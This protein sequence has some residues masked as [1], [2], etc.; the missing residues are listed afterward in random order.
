MR[1]RLA[2]IDSAAARYENI[3]KSRM[4]TRTLCKLTLLISLTALVACTNGSDSEAPSG[5]SKLAL[6]RS[7]YSTTTDA[8]G[9][10]TVQFEVPNGIN[11][12]QL[13]VQSSEGGV[14]FV[15]V[16]GPGATSLDTNNASAG[17]FEAESSIAAI[18]YPHLQERVTP[19]S[20]TA[21]VLVTTGRSKKNPVEGT[22]IAATLL[23]KKD[24]DMNSGVLKVNMALVGP[25]S[26]ADETRDVLEAAVRIWGMIFFR[27]GI[28]LD[29]EWYDFAGPS[30][31]PDPSSG[32]ALYSE[33]ATSVRPGAITMVIASDVRGLGRTRNDRFTSYPSSPGAADPTPLSIAAVSVLEISGRD[34]KFDYY[35]PGSSTTHN[36]EIRL[37]G[38]ELAQLAGHY[39]GL[40]HTVDFGNGSIVSQS[41]NLPDTL[42]CLALTDC[43]TEDLVRSNFM[44]PFPLARQRNGGWGG[45]LPGNNDRYDPSEYRPGREY[46]AREAVTDQQRRV[47]NSSVLVD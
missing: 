1:L 3:I 32:D 39:L 15:S 40:S 16:S 29:V 33:I 41:D 22:P 35:G 30:R 21:R 13:V 24:S 23:T 19:G 34:G 7:T 20:Y 37:A 36:D 6:G 18:N 2:Q 27:A 9:I 28:T 46:F 14:S 8:N 10:A 11:A 31:V 25:V 47:L 4:Y 44:F 42:S 5:T 43:R 17:S 12:F 45:S 38:E 26:D